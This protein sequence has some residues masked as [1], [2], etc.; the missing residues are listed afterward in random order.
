MI[1]TIVCTDRN[2]GIGKT[3]KETGK[4]ELLF[5][6][7]A[8][9]RHFRQTT[10]G[11][12]CVFGY[13]TYMSLPVRPLKNRV[14][15]V[16]WDQATSLDCLEGAITFNTFDSLLNFVKIMSKEYNVYIC[17]GASLYKAFLPYYDEVDITVVDAVDKDATAF[18]PNLEQAG[19]KPK[20]I[21]EY[22]ADKNTNGYYIS[23][24]IWVQDK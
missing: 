6:I 10:L 18:F 17:G 4:G 22:H 23:E 24:Q 15:V 11:N 12:I 16:L 19:Y 20:S 21:M 9:M 8:D 2:H 1:K 5:N 7:P 13:T 3:N 14:N